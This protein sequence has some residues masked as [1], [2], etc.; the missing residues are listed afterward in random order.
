[1]LRRFASTESLSPDTTAIRSWPR[2]SLLDAPVEGLEALGIET[3]GELLEHFP[4]SH[5]NRELV[6]AAQLAIGQEGTVAV[7][8]RTV[9]IKPMRNRR[10]KRVEAR[11][12]DESG[13]LVAV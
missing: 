7:T 10:Q 2:P 1:V 12:F 5:S 9:S 4:H 8:V 11:V 6:P 3:Q 13:P